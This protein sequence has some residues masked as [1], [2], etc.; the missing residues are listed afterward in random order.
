MPRLSALTSRT[1]LRLPLKLPPHPLLTRSPT[2]R[3][4]N[5]HRL[6]T[7]PLIH[8]RH[9]LLLLLPRD[10][11]APRA[12]S[13]NALLLEIPHPSVP[14][15]SL[16]QTTLL[17]P[18]SNSR[19]NSNN[20]TFLDPINTTDLDREILM[21]TGANLTSPSPLKISSQLHLFPATAPVVPMATLFHPFKLMA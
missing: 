9:R 1:L 6:Q 13:T 4:L 7:S 15:S 2:S 16:L 19:N 10:M 11:V 18:S 17:H 21:V 5:S 14:I 20:K 3:H 8:H 12:C